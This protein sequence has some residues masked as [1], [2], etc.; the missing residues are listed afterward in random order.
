MTEVTEA[1]RTDKYG[2]PIQTCTRCHGSGHYSYNQIHGTMCYGCG[3]TGVQ[4]VKKAKPAW[5]AF[6][7]NAKKLK[8]T[9][10]KDLVV[11][12]A[13]R[14]YGSKAERKIVVAVEKTDE[15]CGGS[16]SGDNP[17]VYDYF[18]LVTFED[19]TTEKSSDHLAW[20]RLITLADLNV[21]FYLAQIPQRKVKK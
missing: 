9:M 2:F 1:I 10:T 5:V 11:G 13:Y 16:K 18:Y 15:T 3:G 20:S 12:I 14:T 17:W 19:G 4:I 7:A 21:D 8:Q 6:N